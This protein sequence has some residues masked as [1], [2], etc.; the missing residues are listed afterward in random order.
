[1]TRELAVVHRYVYWS[2]RRIRQVAEN[3]DISLSPRWSWVLRSPSL[4]F[5]PQAEASRER[6]N[7]SRHAVAVRLEAVIG[8]HALS[9]FASPA[10]AVFAK[11]IGDVTFASF[12]PWED[13]RKGVLLHTRVTGSDGCRVEVVLF[14]SL[15]NCA[16]Y[17]AGTK[18]EAPGW[19]S[20]ST[21]D[22][23]R[24]IK[25]RGTRNDSQYDDDESIAVEIVRTIHL[26][27]MTAGKYVFEHAGDAEWFAEVYHDVSLDKERWR[28]RPGSPDMPEKPDRIIIGAPLWVRASSRAPMS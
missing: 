19:S 10:K 9:D 11:G 22:I 20:S 13:K 18:P 7:L 21:R 2:D 8:S 25:S 27:G 28:F 3:N 1:V 5:L 14:G 12:T 17:L 24:F 15:E 6:R 4:S 26:Q 23:E 16:D